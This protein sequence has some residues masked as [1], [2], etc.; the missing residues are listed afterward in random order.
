MVRPAKSHNSRPLWEA[1]HKSAGYGSV[2]MSVAAVVLGLRFV[3][4][5]IA[6]FVLYGVSCL[7]LVIAFVALQYRTSQSRSLMAEFSPLIGGG[8][9]S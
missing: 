2:L 3:Q 9:S 5:S 8:S 4:A 1:I 7:V 6:L